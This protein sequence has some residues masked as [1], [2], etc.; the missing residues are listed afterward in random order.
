MIGGAVYYLTGD[1]KH[2]AWRNIS[3]PG[4]S[5]NVRGSTA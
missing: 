4:V 1:P 5:Q 2:H 3:P